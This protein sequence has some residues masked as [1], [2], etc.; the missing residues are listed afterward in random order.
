MLLSS[1]GAP[2]AAGRSDPRPDLV[3]LALLA[4]RQPGKV[5]LGPLGGQKLRNFL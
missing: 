5:S 3:W 2:A 1:S 4:T